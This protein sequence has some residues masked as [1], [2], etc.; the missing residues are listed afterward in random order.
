MIPNLTDPKYCNPP[1]YSFTHN[2]GHVALCCKN[3]KQNLQVQY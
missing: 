2:D 3:Q 1:N